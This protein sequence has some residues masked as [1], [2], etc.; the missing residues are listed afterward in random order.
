MIKNLVYMEHFTKKNLLLLLKH[1][2]KMASFKNGTKKLRT[3][4]APICS[5]KK[6]FQL[7]VDSTE[8]VADVIRSV[9][10]YSKKSIRFAHSYYTLSDPYY[11]TF[12]IVI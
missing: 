7:S 3:K 10:E 9:K 12:Y 4:I 5:N 2:L 6:K 11:S 1:L 8:N